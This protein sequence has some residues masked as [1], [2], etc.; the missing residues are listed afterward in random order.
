MMEEAMK[1]KTL[2]KGFT[3]IELLVV[4]AIIAILVA[5]LLPAV[6]QAREAARR[7]QCKNNLKQI[8]LAMHNYHDVY[9]TLPIG[10]NNRYGQWGF[11]W[12]VGV[13]PYMDLANVYEGLTQDGDHPGW[14]GT[15]VGNI[16]GTFISG[17]YFAVMRCPSTPLQKFH[18]TGGGKL[19]CLPNYVG[20]AGA[21]DGDGFINNSNHPNQ[22]WNGGVRGKG[23][24]LTHQEVFDFAKITDGTSRTLLVSEQADFGWDP[25]PAPNGNFGRINCEHGWLMGAEHDGG[26]FF[27]LTYLHYPINSANQQGLGTSLVGINNNDGANTGIYSPHTGGAH[28]LLCDGS[29]Q[30][31]NENMDMFI[32]RVLS[33]RDDNQQM[34]EF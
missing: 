27:N 1:R 6:Q 11:S 25:N 30:F 23:G 33:T 14:T 28:G 15:G 29:V 34:G 13:L 10:V 24:A 5:L 19:Q 31:L 18:D 20:I 4:I 2:R 26:R 32:L 3:L 22:G 16:N 9:G 12:W 8:G 21:A 17:Q 7:S